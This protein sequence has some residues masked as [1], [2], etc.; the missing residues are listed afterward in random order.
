MLAIGIIILSSA[1]FFL[2]LQTFKWGDE[3]EGT[4][5]FTLVNYE[6]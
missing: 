6:H 4:H 2:C 5:L 3:E 1:S